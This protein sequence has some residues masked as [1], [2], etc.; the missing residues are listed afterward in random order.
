MTARAALTAAGAWLGRV[1]QML[2]SP[3]AAL[4][5]VDR[6]GGALRDVLW[7]VAV[8]IV[9]FRFATL[10]EALLAFTEPASS[11]FSTLAGVIARE[12]QAAA[13][14]VLPAGVLVTLL[15]GARRDSTKDLDLA[16]ACYVPAFGVHALARA[17]ASL[18]FGG[19]L[20]DRPVQIAAIG[21]ALVA[22]VLA[23]RVA[24]ARMG[25][26]G[27]APIVQPTPAARGAGATLVAVAVVS[28]AAQAAWSGRHLA[29]LLPMRSGRPAPG[30]SLPR[31]D[32][33]PGRVSLAE[34]RGKVVVL[35]F[36]ATWCPPCLAMLPTLHELDAEWK[37]RGVS[38]VGI[39]QDGAVDP[40]TLQ[41]FVASHGIPYPVVADEGDVGGLYKVRALPTMVIIGKDGALRQTFTGFTT[42]G[43]L[44]R[45]LEDAVGEK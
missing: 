42:K 18:P 31:A 44:A 2:V 22:V 19:E 27:A 13:W 37:A 35:D 36:W 21:A 20:P 10:L 28:L 7:L 14:V 24:R 45:A 26:F 43:T 1:G 29:D 17:W 41:E 23:V 5:R 32:G 34:L 39:D 38:F 6:E 11:A 40:A 33:T 4:R 30:F 9:T 15:A 3:R 12:L 8:A 25:G 16:S